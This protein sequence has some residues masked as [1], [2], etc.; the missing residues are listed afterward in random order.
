M[1]H[2]WTRERDNTLT[3]DRRDAAMR[4]ATFRDGT[5]EAVIATGSDVRRMDGRGE[6]IERL[7]VRGADLSTFR[8]ASVLDAHRQ[9]DGVGAVLG[10]IDAVRVE[11]DTLVA[12]IRFS[13]RPEVAGTVRDVQEGI[14]RSVSVGYSVE[15]WRD[16]TDPSSG[17]RTRTAI[18]WTPK[19]VSFVPVPADPRARTRQTDPAPGTRAAINREIRELARRGG[20]A[21]D[22]VDDLIDRSASL[23]VAR[24]AIL[25]DMQARS[26][27]HLRSVHNRSTL[28]NPEVFQRA[29]AEALYARV[30]PSFRPSEVAR[31]FIGLPIFEFAR[32]S[33]TRAG[34]S[35]V[36]MTPSSIITRALGMQTTSDFPLILADT[37]GRSLRDG[38]AAAPSGVRRLSRETT[39]PDFRLKHRL[40]LD[41]TGVTLEAVGEHGEF[42]SGSFVEGGESYKLATYGKI[43]SFSRAA[44]INDDLSAFTDVARRLGAQAAAFERQSLVDLLVSNAGLGPVLSDTK[45]L[46]HTD[47]GNL[48]TPGAAPDE[49]TLA[50]ARLAMRKQTSLGGA[51][52]DVTPWAV[53]IPSDLETDTEKLLSVIQPM[54]TSDVNVFSG[55][56]L[57]VEP[58]LTAAKP[59]FVVADPVLS[60]D[61]EHAY[62]SGASGPQTE[63]RLGFEIDGIQFKV[64]LDW[65][66]GF[67][68]HRGWYRN[69]GGA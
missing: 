13:E 5:V 61:L 25:D 29:A 14:L 1:R 44:M 20:V 55:L 32:L 40:Q 60:G 39:A 3:L 64:R 18:R 33:L 23:D 49:D 50:A 51:L 27:I 15:E 7:D 11:G 68:D 9:H 17:L 67:V 31:Q 38:Y 35:T 8:G 45:A 10:V 63:S 53:L 21:A 56:N 22:V 2:I 37:V 58:R 48:A 41:S 52:I 46:F 62:L 30:A 28:D 4:P 66:C 69:A 6:F 16:G 34:V 43:V 54:Q 57:I 36:G 47:H 26:E 42:R 12:T 24:A 19:E 65:G 59:W